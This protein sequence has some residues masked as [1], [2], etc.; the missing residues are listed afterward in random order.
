MILITS[1][2]HCFRRNES[3]PW[4]LGVFATSLQRIIAPGKSSLLLV[5]E[6]PPQTVQWNPEK[7]RVHLSQRQVTTGTEIAW[8]IGWSSPS[9]LVL[10]TCKGQRTQSNKCTYPKDTK[11]QQKHSAISFR[12]KS[13]FNLK[14]S[15]TAVASTLMDTVAA[16]LSSIFRAWAHSQSLVSLSS[17]R[18]FFQNVWYLICPSV[19]PTSASFYNYVSYIWSHYDPSIHLCIRSPTHLSIHPSE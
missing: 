11:F 3:L 13:Y 14:K 8:E 10:G 16:G 6:K 5:H 1:Q 12:K 18:I 15:Q 17:S 9:D 2:I 19:H 7:A 4:D